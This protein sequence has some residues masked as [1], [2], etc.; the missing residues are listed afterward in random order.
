MNIHLG[1]MVNH[2]EEIEHTSKNK[3]LSSWESGQLRRKDHK[4]KA[5]LSY[6]VS[7]ELV[8]AT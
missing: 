4:S 3:I 2:F 5:N 6:T 1:L 7:S 8:W